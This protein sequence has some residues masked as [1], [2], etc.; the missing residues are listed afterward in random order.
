MAYNF[1][2]KFEHLKK[3]NNSLVSVF[4]NLCGMHYEIYWFLLEPV[5]R[6]QGKHNQTVR[7]KRRRMLWPSCDWCEFFGD[8]C[9]FSGPI[10]EWK[11]A[12]KKKNSP[13]L[14]S[15]F[16]FNL[17]NYGSLPKHGNNL[18]CSFNVQQTHPRRYSFQLYPP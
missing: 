15:T 9:E 4:F 5:M 12:K 17:V 18:S 6:T 13:R 2:N 1:L 3:I 8:W 10:R 14:L 7:L 16:T 11:K